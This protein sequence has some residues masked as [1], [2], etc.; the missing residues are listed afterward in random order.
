MGV[1]SSAQGR[2]AG[3]AGP[4]PG[5][6]QLS[7]G[8]CGLWGPGRDAGFPGRWPRRMQQAGQAAWEDVRMRPGLLPGAARPAMPPLW[9]LHFPELRSPRVRSL[10][11]GRPSET[12]PTPVMEETRPSEGAEGSGGACGQLRSGQGR[13]WLFRNPPSH[14]PFSICPSTRPSPVSKCLSPPPDQEP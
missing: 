12:S 6:P 5:P 8:R 10:K 14:A 9:R 7:A 2:K 11:P 1:S 4:G 3:S 13:R